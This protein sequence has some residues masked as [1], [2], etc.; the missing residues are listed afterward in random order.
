MNYYWDSSALCKLFIDEDHSED[1]YDFFSKALQGDRVVISFLTS[2]E[3]TRVVRRAGLDASRV[4]A[5]LSAL[6]RVEVSPS[7]LTEARDITPHELRSLDAIHLACAKSLR[8]AGVGLV[9]YDKQLLEAAR[10]HG[11]EAISP[12][13]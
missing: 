13:L 8:K 3:T 1:A 10:H 11:L 2:L 6:P 9:S 4:L 12:G 7:I 5:V